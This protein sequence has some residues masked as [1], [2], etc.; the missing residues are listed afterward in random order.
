MPIALIVEDE[1]EANKLLSMLVQL[2]GYETQSAFTGEQALEILADQRPDI[3]FLD[4]ML[5][6]TNGY[7]VCRSIK[8]RRETSA[9]PVVMVTA[10]LAEEN[11]AQSFQVGAHDYIPKP[12]TPDQIF[13]A[14]ASA[15][16]WRRDVEKGDGE[17]EIPVGANDDAFARELSRLRSLLL[18][19]TPLDEEAVSQI[20]QS[21]KDLHEE[22]DRWRDRRPLDPV[23]TLA[24]RLEPDCL[25]MTLRDES[26]WFVDGNV[27]PEL[28]SLYPSLERA[29]DDIGRHDSTPEIVMTRRFDAA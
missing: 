29:F 8:D 27:P 7:D 15:D 9:I 24:Y 19:H 20:V 1:P 6:D 22:A 5:P 25:R 3:V 11:R 17:G 12:Y 10:R 28:V 21:C 26:S 16:A 2:R 14:L 18:V 23:A 13:A 4:L